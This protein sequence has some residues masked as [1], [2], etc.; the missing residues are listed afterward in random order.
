MPIVPKQQQIADLTALAGR[1]DD[2]PKV[3]LNLNAYRERAQYEGEV[4]GGLS[5]DVSGQEAYLRYGAVAATVLER[6]GGRI[7]WDAASYRTVV[8]EEA[9][10]WDEV[11][12]VWYPSVAAFLSLATDEELLAAHVHREAGLE[13][14]VII[15]CESG[16]EAVLAPPSFVR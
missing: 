1:S 7:L 15:C 13:R 12:A 14:A 2:A 11:L 4:P 16:P 10:R 8:G 6:V 3:M 5:A 9:D